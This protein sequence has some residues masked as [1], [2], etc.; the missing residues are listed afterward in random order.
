M[1][2]MATVIR[3]KS[4]KIDECKSLHANV[5]PGI[6]D[7]I[8]RYNIRNYSIYLRDP[9]TLRGKVRRTDLFATYG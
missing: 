1:R 5:W 7:R 4:E 6:L 2:R 3:I 8:S 9:E